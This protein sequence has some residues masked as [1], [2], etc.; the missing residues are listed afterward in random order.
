MAVKRSTFLNFTH[1]P[2]LLSS[3]LTSMKTLGDSGGVDQV[4]FAQDTRDE[5][6]HIRELH[7][8]LFDLHISLESAMR[9]KKFRTLAK[10]KNVPKLR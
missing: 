3:N 10:P 2:F 4:A 1:N 7:A 5:L 6:V 8:L 9:V